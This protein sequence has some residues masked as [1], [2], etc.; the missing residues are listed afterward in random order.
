MTD[1]VSSRGRWFYP[2]FAGA[3]AFFG[4]A[5]AV[6]AYGL[7]DDLFPADLIVVLGNT[8]QTDGTPSP[9]LKARLD[10]AAAL[11]RTAN[12]PLILVSGGVGK[13]GFDE[14]AAMAD[15]LAAAGVPAAALL[16][17]PEGVNTRA[18]AQNT[19]TILRNLRGESAIVVSQ[20]FHVARSVWLLRQAGVK[21]VGHAHALYFEIRDLY[22]LPREM[23]A[24]T[25][26]FFRHP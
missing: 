10:R 3:L 24:L 21:R 13:E 4:L 1:R 7:H 23:A 2:V 8:V 20:Y 15:Y 22:S 14:S 25:A 18:T 19:A 17:D 26:V 12:A 5:G 9:R 11:F 16:R 6:V